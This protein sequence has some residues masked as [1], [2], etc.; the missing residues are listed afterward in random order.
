MGPRSSSRADGRH[1]AFRRAPWS[2]RCSWDTE[3]RP[4]PARVVPQPGDPAT[5]IEMRR[6]DRGRRPA[7]S[8][9]RT[10]PRAGDDLTAAA[11]RLDRSTST[12][13]RAASSTA[14]AKRTSS[15][16][17][18]PPPGD[19]HRARRRRSRCAARSSPQWQ[20]D[21]DRRPTDAPARGS[22]SGEATDADTR[23]SHGAGAGRLACTFHDSDSVKQWK[24]NMNSNVLMQKLVFV[25]LGRAAR[26]CSTCCSRLSV[27]SI[28]VIIERWWY[29]RRRRDD[30]DDAVGSPAQGARRAAT[31][32]AARKRAGG[33]PVR[34]GGDRRAR[35][36]TGT[37][38]A[39][40]RSSRSW[41]RRRALRRKTFEGG[42]LFLGTLG[43][44]APFI[45][46]FGTVL[47]IVTA[48][49]ELGG[50]PD[51]AAHGQRHG[52]HRRGAGR[53]R[54]RHPGR[55][56]RRHLLQRVPEEGRRHRGAGR[57]AR[58]RRASPR[59]RG[60]RTRRA[61]AARRG[62]DGTGEHVG[63]RRRRW[64]PS[65]AGTM[66]SGGG[67]ARTIAAINVTPLVDVVLVLL[68]ILM[69]ASTYIVAQTLK[70]QLPARQVDRRHRRQ[71][72]QGRAPQGRH[73]A[74]E[75]GPVTE[76]SWPRR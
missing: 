76:P 66:A 40:R 24:G 7:R 74:L 3:R 26:R 53:H 73:A 14:A 20:R 58:Q 63:P 31:S 1:A 60:T 52:R 17:A 9:Q 62:A 71:A 41:P 59:M 51:A 34:R 6:Q 64:R 68:V 48:F 69:V 38:T 35:R 18:A 55:A 32:T 56:A 49:R 29:F 75:R 21:V 72:D 28:G 67:R 15:S 22:R 8:C 23:G 5:P 45:G 25:A 16:T 57:R 65:M 13:T 10:R 39:P 19:V 37:T 44:N 12:P 54:G 43:N 46:L 4:G 47:G 70:V 27:L 61:R 2:S 11:Q 50:Q 42:L 36:S 33:E 30:V